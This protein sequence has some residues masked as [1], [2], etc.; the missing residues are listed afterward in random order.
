ME[1]EGTSPWYSEANKELILAELFTPV[2]DWLQFPFWSGTARPHGTSVPA[3]PP[4][5]SCFNSCPRS[6]VHLQS[7]VLARS[8]PLTLHQG[9]QGNS[10]VPILQQGQLSSAETRMGKSSSSLPQSAQCWLTSSWWGLQL[11]PFPR[12]A[13]PAATT[14][15]NMFWLFSLFALCASHYTYSSCFFCAPTASPRGTGFLFLWFVTYSAGPYSCANSELGHRGMFKGE[16]QEHVSQNSLGS[17]HRCTGADVMH[18][19][20]RI[21]LW[22]SL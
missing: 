18:V 12:G 7:A 20:C 4:L 14:I 3:N 9:A 19:L 10:L 15:K 17:K 8:S 13:H 22:N 6:I 2:S 1:E 5:S 21:N 11:Q 16:S